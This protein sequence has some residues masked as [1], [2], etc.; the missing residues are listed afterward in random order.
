MTFPAKAQDINAIWPECWR[1]MSDAINMT[2]RID[3][4]PDMPCP[5]EM[6]YGKRPLRSPL[7]FLMPG[8]HHARRASK[9]DPKGELCFLLNSGDRHSRDSYKVLFR[10]GLA[11]YTTDVVFGYSRRARF[12]GVVATYGGGAVGDPWEDQQG[13]GGGG[14]S[15]GH[16]GS[17]HG[18][19]GIGDRIGRGRIFPH[20]HTF[21]P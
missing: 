6:F 7:P 10:S 4:K 16:G 2:A 20:K 17:M 13:W 19:D 14:G 8:V 9:I 3:M 18:G 12:T 15:G 11:G 5:Y 21:L 1:W